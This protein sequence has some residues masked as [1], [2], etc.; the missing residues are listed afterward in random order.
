MATVRD[1]KVGD[2]IVVADGFDVGGEVRE[3][4]MTV[5]HVEPPMSAGRAESAG[6]WVMAE[7]RKGGY[8]TGFDDRSKRTWRMATPEEVAEHETFLRGLDG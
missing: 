3:H 6:P 7:L 5:W 4:T 8:A 1:L 2:V